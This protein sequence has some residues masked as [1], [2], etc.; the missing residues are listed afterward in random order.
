MDKLAIHSL[1]LLLLPP[2][3]AAQQP[4]AFSEASAIRARQVLEQGIDA[5]G[6][7]A[8]LQR[9]TTVSRE[10]SG[11][12]T[13]VGQGGRPVPYPRVA[14]Q[15]GAVPRALSHPQLLSL[16]DYR[17][18]R[19]VEYLR[20]E[21][22]GGQQLNARTVVGRDSAFVVYYDYVYHAWRTIPG[23]QL[24]TRRAALFRRYP[25]GVLLA[26]WNRPETLRWLGEARWHNQ[27]HGVIGFADQD[28][29]AVTLFFDA[30][31]HR[32][33]KL[34]SLGDDGVLGD[35]AAE[36]VYD[37]YR[38]VGDVLMP[39]RYVDRVGG[40]VLQEMQASRITR[41]SA[42]SDTLFVRP[43][44]FP[45]VQLGP[46]FPTVRPLG[47]DAYAVL[48]GYNCV[49]VAFDDYVVVLEA[50][51]SVREADA[52]IGRIR[53]VA[54]G[55]P[56][57]Y[58][59]S[60]HWNYDHLAG[61]RPYVALGATIV[62]PPTAQEAIRLAVASARPLHPDALSRA[63]RAPIFESLDGPRRVFSDGHHVV[64][65]HDL[66][67][68]PHADEMYIAYLP[69]QRVL[70][71]ADLL[72]I[73]VPG[74]AGTGGEDT[75]DLAAK[76]ERLGLAVATIIPVHGQIGTPADLQQAL[77]RRGSP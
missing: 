69:A 13:D 70:F 19:A 63:P 6:G 57:R 45:E 25:E 39:Y 65:I 52:V 17:G 33:A 59:V 22:Y 62:A 2:V 28:G 38:P 56:I 15:V 46:S 72:D 58:V 21:I 53:D 37:D 76:L 48:G 30:A 16:R 71:E 5:I 3:L 60:T 43:A 26:A 27:P 73:T 29:T 8:A 20:A 61:I 68:S 34:E 1:G 42:L 55:K 7:L 75:A 36:V 18:L 23:G 66:T 32:L 74:R 9:L 11:I 47:G 67:P 35:V 50:G 44:G 54:P 77:S 51:G 4:A 14:D 31:T 12:R 24:A 64:E 41:D 49:F 10:L 40:V